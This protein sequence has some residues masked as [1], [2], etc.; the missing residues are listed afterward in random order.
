MCDR[1]R[2]GPAEEEEAC[3]ACDGDPETAGAGNVGT[4][5]WEMSD[6]PWPHE[7][8]DDDEDADDGA[9]DGHPTSFDG[10]T[11]D[12]D[13]ATVPKQKRCR[14]RRHRRKAKASAGPVVS[15]TT[16]FEATRDGGRALDGAPDGHPTDADEDPSGTTGEMSDAPWP[17]EAADD[18]DADDG[19]PDGHST[20][21]DKETLDEDPVTV[22]K[23]KQRCRSRRRHKAKASAGLMVPTTTGFEA[24]RDG[25]RAL[26]RAPDGQPTDADEDPSDTMGDGI[27]HHDV[28]PR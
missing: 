12:E 8:A 14:R 4:P 25:G 13:P 17:H 24:T 18:E 26:D 19:A 9:P 3:W 22:P 21:F 23:Q 20:S 15:T 6:A 11:P 10:E 7:A 16:E 1:C 28:S 5:T 2:C 27:T